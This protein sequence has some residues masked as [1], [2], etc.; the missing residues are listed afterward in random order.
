M[1]SAAAHCECSTHTPCRMSSN[2]LHPVVSMT[3]SWRCWKMTLA[4]LKPMGTC[5]QAAHEQS[6]GCITSENSDFVRGKEAMQ[7]SEMMHGSAEAKK[8]A[9]TCFMKLVGSLLADALDG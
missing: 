4:E 9:R 2:S 5:F 1:T 6:S 3:I 7:C 8:G